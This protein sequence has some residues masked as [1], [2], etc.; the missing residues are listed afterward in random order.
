M[1][2]KRYLALAIVILFVAAMLIGCQTTPTTTQS[3]TA[4]PTTT[5]SGTTTQ[6]TTTAPAPHGMNLEGYPIVDEPVTVDIMTRLHSSQTQYENMIV[7]Q[8]MEKLTNVKVNWI[9]V[10][11]DGFVE[12][13]NIS[14]A[15]GDLP[16]AFAKS[17]MSVNDVMKFATSGAMVPLNP[18]L[19]TYAPNLDS[20]LKANPVVNAGVTMLDGNIYGAPYILES[21]A[22]RVQARMFFDV[23]LM[24]K[25]GGSM[26]KTTDDFIEY[27]KLIR[28]NDANDNGDP[29][30]EVPLV[31]GSLG[32]IA[33]MTAG[34]FGL[35]MNGAS[36]ALV[37]MPEGSNDLRFLPTEN[38][39][40]EQMK[41]LRTLYAERLVDQEI[42]TT[43]STKAL[44]LVSQKQAGAIVWW[45]T[46][47]V[48]G[49]K[50]DD[51]T[52]LER[53]L[54]GPNGHSAFTCVIGSVN[55]PAAFIITSK[56]EIPE[57]LVRWIDILYSEE[58]ILWYVLGKE[59]VTFEWGS[60]GVPYYKEIIMKNPNGLSLMEAYG[61]Y[62]PRIGGSDPTILTE[63]LYVY[64]EGLP[65]SRA[66]SDSMK[67]DIID[68]TDAWESFVYTSAE[69]EVM[70]SISAD[71]G[72]YVNESRAKFVSGELDIFN[73]S[74]WNT[75]V[76]E[77]KNIGLADY[78]TLYRIGYDRFI[79]NK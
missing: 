71:I 19:E 70:S 54:I 78:L 27:L 43:T 60:D 17:G 52:H 64:G 34:S 58:G 30:D 35:N 20:Y 22:I 63:E 16:D 8:E 28:D 65:K 1:M 72:S 13:R 29:N 40:R 66:A 33:Q 23:D 32:H 41:F 2:K 6:A 46:S 67:D 11:W 36:H 51:Y 56:C 10:P 39:Y 76:S 38:D 37:D 25:V 48:P 3:T 12:R 79:S 53:Q 15:T 55:N 68:F 31:S 42:F 59:G 69:A 5:G 45:S 44:A 50:E 77:F 74:V 14:F 61:Q 24:G 73:D 47:F 49:G 4:A 26:P 7:W 21:S 18:Y 9:Y 57:I 62:M 75:Y